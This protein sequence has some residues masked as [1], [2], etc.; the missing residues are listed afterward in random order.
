MRTTPSG[1]APIDVIK[2]SA[3]KRQREGTYE[4]QRENALRNA[5]LCLKQGAL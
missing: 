4:E 1:T 2:P 5:E 3:A